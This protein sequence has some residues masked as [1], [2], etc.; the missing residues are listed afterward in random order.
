MRLNSPEDEE[1]KDAVHRR[2]ASSVIRTEVIVF[3][4]HGAKT[5]A[6]SMTLIVPKEWLGIP[7]VVKSEGFCA[8][9]QCINFGLWF[10]V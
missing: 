10:S 1:K 5:R 6:T 4:L 2:R 3:L 9:D 8:D 7:S